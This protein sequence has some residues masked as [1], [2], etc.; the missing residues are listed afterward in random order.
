MTRSDWVPVVERGQTPCSGCGQVIDPDGEWRLDAT[1][2]PAHWCCTDLGA[3]RS[4]AEPKS[5]TRRS[6]KW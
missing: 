6:R 2:R 3:A 5:A 1:G 4:V